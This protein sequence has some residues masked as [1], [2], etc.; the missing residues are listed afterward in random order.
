MASAI[1]LR[2][3]LLAGLGSVIVA[4][5]L[6]LAILL[7]N[8]AESAVPLT[9]KF[10]GNT[11]IAEDNLAAILEITNSSAR[12]VEYVVYPI[13]SH[14]PDG[15]PQD[16]PDYGGLPLLRNLPPR[17]V[18]NAVVSLTEVASKFRYPVEFHFVPTHLERALKRMRQSIQ[19]RSLKPLWQRT[20]GRD[21][22]LTPACFLFSQ[23][24]PAFETHTRAGH[25]EL[26]E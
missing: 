17:G 5:L 13:Q 6:M 10:A 21:Y 12:T 11:N 14:G 26:H 4:C 22:Q 1:K 19:S 24:I 20:Y 7:R 18:T 15:W 2:T 25:N 23:E 9:V 16:L 8:E 3:V